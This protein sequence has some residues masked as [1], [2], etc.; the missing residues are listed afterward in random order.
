MF[1]DSQSQH[2][3][4]VVVHTSTEASNRVSNLFPVPPDGDSSLHRLSVLRQARTSLSVSNCGTV[5][6][7][8]RLRLHRFAFNRIDEVVHHM[9]A[10]SGTVQFDVGRTRYTV[11][12][13]RPHLGS[14]IGGGLAMLICTGVVLQKGRHVRTN[15]SL[16]GNFLICNFELASYGNLHALS[17]IIHPL[18]ISSGHCGF[19]ILFAFRHKRI[20]LP[21]SHH[22]VVSELN[23]QSW[24]DSNSLI[25]IFTNDKLCPTTNFLFS[26]AIPCLSIRNFSN[27]KS[28]T[29]KGI[30]REGRSIVEVRIGHHTGLSLR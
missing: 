8:R 11:L 5:Q 28:M 4:G 13:A 15:L 2:M 24:S 30:E 12:F 25:I 19:G 1:F 3:V 10:T 9:D 21:A 20:R 6:G 26:C 17:Q 14:N 29:H 7:S 27:L 18:W 23:L 22:F 16:E